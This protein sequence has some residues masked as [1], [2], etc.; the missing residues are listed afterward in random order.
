MN[1][2]TVIG[3]VAAS[4]TTIS[5]LPQALKTIRTKHTQDLS[6]SMYIVITSGI[7][8]W[9]VYGFLIMDWPIILANA[10]TLVFSIIILIFK[11]KYK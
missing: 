2:I 1:G 10:I 6:L 8:L 7:L 9:L 4:L 5:F 11:L 3:L